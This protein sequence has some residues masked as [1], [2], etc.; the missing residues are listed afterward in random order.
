MSFIE[1]VASVDRSVL[2]ALGEAIIL[3]SGNS[4]QGV[5]EYPSADGDLG[6]LPM[7]YRSPAV[8][9]QASDALALNKGD[10][11]TIRESGYTV[12]ECFP[13]GDGLLVVQ[14]TEDQTDPDQGLW[15]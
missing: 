9:L 3:P 5:F 8:T 2:L 7:D 10:H 4:V 14:L 12:S 1:S 11:L 13:T 15:K 6:S